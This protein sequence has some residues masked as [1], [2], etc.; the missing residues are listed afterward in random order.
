MPVLT[1]LRLYKTVKSDRI[2]GFLILHFVDT[3]G[4]HARRERNKSAMCTAVEQAKLITK[5]H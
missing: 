3:I 2:K 4:F 1:Y 5:L